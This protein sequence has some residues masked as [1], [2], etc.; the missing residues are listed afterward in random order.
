MTISV[1]FKCLKMPLCMIYNSVVYLQY[2]LAD[3]LCLPY[4]LL[5][6][7]SSMAEV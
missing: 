3:M 4:I 1:P 6:L 7:L 2:V 5:L